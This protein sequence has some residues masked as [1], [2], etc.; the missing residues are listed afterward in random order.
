MSRRDKG[1]PARAE[2]V[3]TLLEGGDHGGARA[4]ARGLLAD[5]EANE[6]ERKVARA[7][8]DGLAPDRGAVIAGVVGAIAALAI[9]LWTV[10][11]G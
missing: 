8:L 1:R 10:T 9:G 3:R 4:E 5:P 7:A 6:A 2:R 11:R